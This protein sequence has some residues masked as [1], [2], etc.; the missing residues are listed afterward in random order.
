MSSPIDAAD[1]D[2]LT[3]ICNRAAE[4]KELGRW[5][6]D[7][8]GFVLCLMRLD[9]LRYVNQYGISSA[10]RTLSSRWRSL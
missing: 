8:Q 3:K 9:S 6:A 5:I 10:G 7:G 1:M 4:E 2:T